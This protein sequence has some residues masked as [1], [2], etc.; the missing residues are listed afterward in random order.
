MQVLTQN[1]GSGSFYVELKYVGSSPNTFNYAAAVTVTHDFFGSNVSDD[2][3]ILGNAIIQP[4]KEF[5]V[6]LG[7]WNTAANW[8]PGGVPTSTD[9]VLIPAGNS[10]NI[11]GVAGA[12]AD[13]V[14]VEAGAF[15]KQ[16]SNTTF[17]DLKV[18]ASGGYRLD[19][20]IYT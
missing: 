12:D 3:D 15:V 17:T 7:D 2:L 10:V 16:S 14:T 13:L 19:A 8:C 5:I 9:T 18:E 6:G 1:F 20:G 11:V 4:F